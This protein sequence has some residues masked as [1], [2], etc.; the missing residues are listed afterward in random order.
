MRIASVCIDYP[1][2][3][4]PWSGLF[5]RRRLA[6]LSR[7]ADVRVIHPEPWF[8]GLR[9][10]GRG[11]PGPHLD[12]GP[13]AAHLPMFYLPG[14]LKGL[15]GR[16]VARVVAP[17]VRDLDAERPIDLIDAHFGY[18]E[19]VGC[20]RAALELGLP[21]FI[22]MR[23]LER[24]VLAHR[25]RRSQL[26]WALGLCSGVVCVSESLKSLAVAGGVDPEKIRVIPNAVDRRMF[27]PGD[28]GEARRALGVDPGT[29]LVVSVG[30]LEHRKGYHILVRALNRIRRDDPEVRLA[31]IGGV[32]HEPRYGPRLQ[33]MIA[34]LGLSDRVR[35]VGSQPP[36]QVATW[37]RAADLFALPTYD[38]GCCN[39]VLEAM[40]CG[41]P[42]VTTP[43]GD[44]ASLVD[45]PSRGRIVPL[46]DEHALADGIAEALRTPWDRPAIAAHGAGYTWEEVGRRT[47]EFFRDR[48]GAEGRH[49]TERN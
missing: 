45:P 14:V 17:A 46:E 7:V 36:E 9:P 20:V 32:T 43:A 38:E 4:S 39:S 10:R 21:V 8:P 42:V 5:V 29:R 24:Q 27:A 49:R 48:L 12:D 28:Q 2:P 33:A 19:G 35:L 25:R 6:G 47:A 13:P 41:L 1:G 34:E 16:W 37:L 31:I 40:A 11:V 15:D 44:N 3:R 18:P 22:T 23:G 30:Q 26:L